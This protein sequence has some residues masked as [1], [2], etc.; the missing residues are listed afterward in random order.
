LTWIHRL[1]VAFE[2]IAA[3]LEEANRLDAESNLMSR[4]M[5]NELMGRL[6]AMQAVAGASIPVKRAE[7]VSLPGGL[8]PAPTGPDGV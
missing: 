4:G 5:S 1:V 7:I 2:R 8:P 3:A 6:D